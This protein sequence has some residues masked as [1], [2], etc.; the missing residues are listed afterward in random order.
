MECMQAGGVFGE[1]KFKTD[2][3]KDAEYREIFVFHISLTSRTE[4]LKA[5]GGFSKLIT[6]LE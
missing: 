1:K 4:G 5:R 6:E 3:R 2:R